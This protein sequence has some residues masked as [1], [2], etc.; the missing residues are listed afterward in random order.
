M[1][2]EEWREY[3]TTFMCVQLASHCIQIL[4]AFGSLVKEE[5]FTSGEYSVGVRLL[6]Y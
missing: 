3:N 2:C 1:T 5:W 4:Y 6:N